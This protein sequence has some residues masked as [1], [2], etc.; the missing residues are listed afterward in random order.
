ML[1]RADIA[2]QAPGAAVHAAR[3]DAWMLGLDAV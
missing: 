3:L 2:T 1:N